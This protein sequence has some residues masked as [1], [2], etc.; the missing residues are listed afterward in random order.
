MAKLEEWKLL[1]NTLIIF[2][3]DNGM[4]GGGSGQGVMG[5]TADGREMAFHNTNM[6]GLKGSPDEGGV[7]VPFF[8]RWDNHIHSGRDIET[9]AAHIDI[10]PTLVALAGQDGPP[11]QV[12]GRSLLPLI[13]GAVVEWPDRFLFTHQGRWP[14]GSNPDD[15]QWKNFAVRNQR[16][17]L[18][19]NTALFDMEKDPGQTTNVIDQHP[20]LVQTMRAAYEQWWRE[21]RPLMVNENVLMSPTRPFHVLY[22]QQL[23]STGIPEWKP[24]AL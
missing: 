14:T 6:K 22:E 13:D 3:S 17:R 23:N 21:T 19:D 7:R 9:I 16:F 1:E 5:T 11:G 2:M 10:F 18:V 20:E 24:P 15:F 12:E 4:T 8:V